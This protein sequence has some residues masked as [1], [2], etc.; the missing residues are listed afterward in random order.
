MDIRQFNKTDI[1]YAKL[2]AITDQIT[3]YEKGKNIEHIQK[4]AF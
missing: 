1:W 2:L 3:S 4:S